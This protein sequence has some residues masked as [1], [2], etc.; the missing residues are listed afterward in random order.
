MTAP[1]AQGRSSPPQPSESLP[2][3]ARRSRGSVFASAAG[4]LAGALRRLFPAFAA[5]GVPPSR[6]VGAFLAAAT[7]LTALLALPVFAQAQTTVWSAT[8]TVKQLQPAILGCSIHI[9]TGECSSV[10]IVTD[11]DFTYDSTDYTVTSIYLRSSGRFEIYFDTDLTTAAQTLTLD[12]AGTTFA[13]A[14]ANVEEDRRRY[15][16]SSGL[17]WS[18]GDTVA[19]KLVDTAATPTAPGV[20]RDLTATPGDGQVTLNWLAPSSNGGSAITDYD[21][22]YKVGSGA[23]G[24]WTSAGTDLTETVENLTNGQVHTFEVRAVNTVGDGEA[25]SRT[26]TPATAPRITGMSITS[27]PADG[28]GVY[29]TGERI[30]VTVEF[31]QAVTVT[32]TA[33]LSMEID[34]GPAGLAGVIYRRGSPGSA[35][36]FETVELLS[37]YSDGDGVSIPA[38]SILL[39]GANSTIRSAE[40]V[41]AVLTYLGIAPD[42]GHR[43]NV[44]AGP[45]VPGAPTGLFATAAGP[46]SINLYWTAPTVTG[47]VAISGYK[48][49]VCS[50]DC[51]VEANWTDVEADTGSTATTYSHTGLSLGDTRHYRVSAINSGGTGA[52]SITD[53]ATTITQS[54][55]PSAPPKPD[56]DC[57]QRAGRADLGRAI[58]R[59]RP[60]HRDLL[61]P[62]QGGER[63]VRT[64]D[65]HRSSVADRDGERPD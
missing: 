47:G 12:V 50:T 59:R 20:P 17:S 29:K 56:G 16:D 8:L 11:D 1:A 19:L 13:F 35:L 3:A 53:S 41:D 5:C 23:F 54:G 2:P 30:E 32:G 61:L 4:R 65:H 24:S 39:I 43:V 26:A 44:A 15:W 27:T 45:G 6:R 31:D 63:G 64:K 7:V 46:T 37:S 55:P 34:M 9:A 40:G 10:S 28:D 36:V 33:L 62:L 51:T 58:E 49:E 22:R 48:I 38:D 21:Y 52:A 60:G 42:A 57:R 25:A 18:A 14:D